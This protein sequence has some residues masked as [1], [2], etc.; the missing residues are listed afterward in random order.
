MLGSIQQYVRGLLDGAPLPGEV[1]GPLTAWVTPPVWERI[2]EPRAYVWGGR[3]RTTRQA[4][5]RGAARKTFAWT[6]D[7]YVNWLTTPDNALAAEPFP[8]VVDTVIGVL[9][10]AAMPVFI[11]T[12]GNV[13]GVNATSPSDTQILSIGEE[14][15]LDYPPERSVDKQRTIWYGARLAAS[16]TEVVTG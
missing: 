14:M 5:P 8:F 9:S 10:A 12:S 1:P 7:I 2:P 16:V 3:L 11:D 6:V 15:E 13:V 4:G